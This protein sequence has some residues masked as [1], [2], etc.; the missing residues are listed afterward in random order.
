MNK[1]IFLI[2]TAV[3]VI[4]AAIAG[5]LDKAHAQDSNGNRPFRNIHGSIGY[6]GIAVTE[7]DGQKFLVV[8]CADGLSVVKF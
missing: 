2:I 3:V 6:V 5:S 1:K 4:F 8:R 7:V